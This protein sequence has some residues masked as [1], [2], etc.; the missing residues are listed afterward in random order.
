MVLVRRPELAPQFMFPD[1]GLG[2]IMSNLEYYHGYTV[3]DT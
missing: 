3:D 2:E 1:N